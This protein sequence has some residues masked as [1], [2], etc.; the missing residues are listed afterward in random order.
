[1][2]EKGSRAGGYYAACRGD[3]GII[4]YLYDINMVSLDNVYLGAVQFGHLDV[5]KF[6]WEK[7]CNHSDVVGGHIHILQ[8]LYDNDLISV[9]V[10]VSRKVASSGNL[11]SLQYLHSKNF[12][13]LDDSVFLAAIASTNIEMI[14]WLHDLECPIVHKRGQFFDSYLPTDVAIANNSD[15]LLQ[16]LKL[17]FEWGSEF[18][19]YNCGQVAKTGNLEGLK[20]LYSC[21]CK[22]D[23]T[24]IKI[25]AKNGH[26][27][28][29]VWAREQGCEW[30]ASACNAIIKHNHIDVLKWLRGINRDT[31]GLVSN[32]TEICPWNKKSFRRILDR[33]RPNLDI[34][35]Y[36][37]DK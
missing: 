9:D 21:G 36:E 31:C 19:D 28:I 8:W 7:G 37:F 32:E 10:S 11:E 30:D 18:D 2:I 12:P 16:I 13:L 20:Y 23:E 24:I 3:L 14:S 6:V 34:A 35:V 25:A 33:D 29:I 15:N 4:K 1:M 26:L 27:H 22:L 17:L 5:I